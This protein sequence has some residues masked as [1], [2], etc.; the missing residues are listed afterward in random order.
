MNLA[1]KGDSTSFSNPIVTR[2]DFTY[3]IRLNRIKIVD[4]NTGKASVTNDIKISRT[5]YARSKLGTKAQLPAIES[6]TGT[7]TVVGMA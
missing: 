3:S 2:A 5:Y 1:H 7:P 4:L 6:C